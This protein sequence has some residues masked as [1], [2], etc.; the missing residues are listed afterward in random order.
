MSPTS[1]KYV[2]FFRNVNLGQ[3]NNPSRIELESAFTAA[4]GSDAVSFITTGNVVFS[5]DT[6]TEAREVLAGARQILKKQRGLEEPAYLRSLAYLAGLVES[7]PFASVRSDDVFDYG[8]TFIDT[9]G[10]ERLDTPVESAR[11][12]LTIF[13]FTKGE[14][15]S[16]SRVV[17]GRAGNP[18]PV[19]EKLLGVPASTRVWNTVVRIVQKYA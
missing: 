1:K 15:F 6:P 2:A 4:G 16:V 9:K 3:F 11:G 10:L 19:L 18:G 5:A 13:R 14:A 17:D 8:V 12:D 7:D